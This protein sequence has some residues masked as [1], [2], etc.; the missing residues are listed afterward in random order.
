M[1]LVRAWTL[2]LSV[3]CHYSTLRCVLY[4]CECLFTLR[5]PQAGSC[6]CGPNLTCFKNN[7]YSVVNIILCIQCMEAYL[8]SNGQ[9]IVVPQKCNVK[10]CN[11]HCRRDHDCYCLA[12]FHQEN[13]THNAMSHPRVTYMRICWFNHMLYLRARL[14]KEW[15]S[16]NPRLVWI[17]IS[18]L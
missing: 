2:I 12:L 9:V 7:H 11:H 8:V 6:W 13:D 4:W 10:W 18:V 14:F 15:L 1:T 16:L 17:L 3:R 5:R